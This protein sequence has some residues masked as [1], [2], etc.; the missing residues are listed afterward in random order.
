[1]APGAGFEPARRKRAT[2]LA[3]LPPTR[4]G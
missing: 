3:G 4:L 1:M 2:G